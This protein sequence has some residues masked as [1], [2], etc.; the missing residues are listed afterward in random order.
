[1]K[2]I[3]NL[4]LY[5]LLIIGLFSCK[6][7]VDVTGNYLTLFR[8]NPRTLNIYKAHKFTFNADSTFNYSYVVIGSVEKYSSGIWKRI[9]E[10]TIL[11]N[12][13]VKNNVIPVYIEKSKSDKTQ[14]CTNLVITQKKLKNP[15]WEYTDKSYYVI[16]YINDK[17]YLDL[18]PE[19]S[20]E[21]ITISLREMIGLPPDKSDKDIMNVPPVKRGNYC[22][23]LEE[24]VKSIYF[25]IEKQREMSIGARTFYRL[26][27]EKINIPMQPNESFVVNIALNDSLF[28]Y[29]IFDNTLLNFKGKKLIF[30]DKEDNNKTN[31]LIKSK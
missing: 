2:S 6:T 21:P 17:N 9:D 4:L 13:E 22:L 11:L 15:R 24:P 30:K 25:E 7:T 10:N 14:I 23:T 3:T 29:R 16:P 8:N 19:L 20:D 12:S 18:H 1:M 5:C 27:T 31:K 26:K 28:S